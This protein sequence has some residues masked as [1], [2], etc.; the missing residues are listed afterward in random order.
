MIGGR[1]MPGVYVKGMRI[2]EYIGYPQTMIFELVDNQ[3]TNI[4]N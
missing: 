1:T 2:E 4:T 3:I